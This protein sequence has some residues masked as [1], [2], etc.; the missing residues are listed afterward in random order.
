MLLQKILFTIFVIF[1]LY[2]CG[3]VIILAEKSSYLID[4]TNP[5][6]NRI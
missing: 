6:D 2:L 5:I 1:E 3:F 4:L